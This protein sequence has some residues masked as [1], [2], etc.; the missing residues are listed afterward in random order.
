MTRDIF[1]VPLVALHDYDALRALIK[2]SLN[3]N[4][5]YLA[6]LGMIV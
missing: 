1:R 6:V 2:D 3:N 4:C 5:N